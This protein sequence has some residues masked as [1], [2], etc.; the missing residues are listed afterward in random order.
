MSEVYVLEILKIGSLF[1]LIVDII[2]ERPQRRR[3]NICLHSVAHARAREHDRRRRRADWDRG[4]GRSS[5]DSTILFCSLIENEPYVDIFS[6]PRTH[7][8]LIMFVFFSLRNEERMHVVFPFLRC[9]YY[10]S[11]RIN[12]QF[13]VRSGKQML[14][15][16]GLGHGRRI[17]LSKNGF[18]RIRHGKMTKKPNRAMLS[19]EW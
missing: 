4:K 18:R 6:C 17:H 19:K 8:M 11:Q 2:C 9:E 12:K 13:T 1:P 16:S 15:R 14:L 5:R 7:V 10:T 3:S